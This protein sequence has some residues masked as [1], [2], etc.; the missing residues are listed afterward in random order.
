MHKQTL[1]ERYLAEATAVD[2]TADPRSRLQV[3]DYVIR[4]LAP[5]PPKTVLHAPPEMA[6][7]FVFAEHPALVVGKLIGAGLLRV[8]QL[9]AALRMPS[10]RMWLEYPEDEG[11]SGLLAVR[12]GGGSRI[13][14][15]CVH[16]WKD[17]HPLAHVEVDGLRNGCVV[18][19]LW[20]FHS[21]YAREYM[22]QDVSSFMSAL[23]LLCVPRLCEVR[24]SPGLPGKIARTAREFPAV[25]F[26]Q[27]KSVIGGKSVRY[28]SPRKEGET[29][30]EYRKRLHH[31]VGH[32]RTYK[33]KWG[34]HGEAERPGGPVI[35]WVPDH[36]RGSAE[37]GIVIKEHL[38]QQKEAPMA[39]Q[40][41]KR[42]T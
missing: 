31:V 24:T 23:F 29:E 3:H 32:F 16:G 19:V 35:A 10:S 30:V 8:E 27:V 15:T 12:T 6:D 37:R 33:M 39:G 18:D 1:A 2:G 5:P 20:T 34:S 36:W 13:A 41:G 21:N 26:K 38:M 17:V 25:E 40:P 11:S 9:Y 14:L 28:L 4:A 22:N 7:R 42:D